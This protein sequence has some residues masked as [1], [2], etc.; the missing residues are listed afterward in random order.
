VPGVS[1][2]NAAAAA[3]RVPLTKRGIAET[4]TIHAGRPKDP[5]AARTAIAGDRE[6]IVVLMG[7]EVVEAIVRSL[8]ARGKHPDQPALAVSQAGTAAEKIVSGTLGTIATLIRN[9]NV[10]S[11]A[12]LIVGGVAASTHAPTVPMDTGQRITTKH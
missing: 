9:Q 2:V 8:I 4:V 3:A 10:S 5:V 11:P 12:T 1:S 7:L 6:T